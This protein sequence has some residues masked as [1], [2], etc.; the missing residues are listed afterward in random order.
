MMPLY[1]C[2]GKTSAFNWLNRVRLVGFLVASLCFVVG[3]AVGQES[4]HDKSVQLIGIDSIYLNCP[5]LD[6]MGELLE[7]YIQWDEKTFAHHYSKKT[8]EKSPVNV[9]E[10][11]LIKI[12]R[13]EEPLNKN[14]SGA[15]DYFAAINGLAF[16]QS[17]EGIPELLRIGA[18]QITKD[19][20]FRHN[21]VKA[22]GAIGD[23]AVVPQLIPLIYHFNF[24]TRMDAQIALVRLTGQNFGYNPE[25][26]GNWWNENKDSMGEN[27]PS[28]DKELVNWISVPIRE[29][30]KATYQQM[31]D[32]EDFK[33]YFDP[34]FQQK[35]DKEIFQRMQ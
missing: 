31:I 34:A 10:P 14:A 32:S 19:N 12:L 26:W 22:L 7:K 24:N 21:A 18:E 16:L 30:L 8:F 2:T 27:L 4:N 25:D 28:Y 6:K 29:E 5:H 20:A 9:M 23:P 15:Q 3:C 1:Q 11:V 13:Q 33:N 35:S 17:K